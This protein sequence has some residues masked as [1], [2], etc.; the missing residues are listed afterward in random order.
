VARFVSS[1]RTVDLLG[2]QQIAGIPTAIHE[3]FKNAHDAYADNVNVDFFRSDRL[4]VVRD[5]GVGMTREDLEKRWLVVG[6]PSKMGRGAVLRPPIDSKKQ[7]RPVLG[8]KGIGRLAVGI[9]GPQVLVVSRAERD[10]KLQNLA[11][12]YVHWAIFAEPDLSLDEIEIPVREFLDPGALNAQAVGEMTDEFAACIMT[13]SKSGRL[14]PNRG[15]KILREV[16]SF[17]LDP[18]EQER[19]LKGPESLRLVAGNRGTQFWVLPAD[20]ILDDDLKEPE[21]KASPMALALLGFADAMS[22]GCPPPVLRVAFRDHRTPVDVVDVLD[23]ARFFD[24]GDFENADHLICGS[25]DEFGQFRGSI[26]VYGEELRASIPFSKAKGGRTS[27]G[28]FELNIAYVHGQQRASTLPDVEW[29]RFMQRARKHGGVYVYLDGIRVLPFGSPEFDWLEIEERRSRSAG[30][31]FFSH[32]VMCGSVRL[33]RA[34]NQGL[35]EKAGREG[36]IKNAAYLDLRRVLV[37]LLIRFAADYF[38]EGGERAQRFE[39]ERARLKRKAEARARRE[40]GSRAK[41][42]D[43]VKSLRTA[44]GLLASPSFKEQFEQIAAAFTAK[45]SAVALTDPG[46][47]LTSIEMA[48]RDAMN[49]LTEQQKRIQVQRPRVGIKE[50]IN[51]EWV[52]HEQMAEAFIG[53]IIRPLRQRV[54]DEL[55][56][57][58]SIFVSKE[59]ARERMFR[60][61]AEQSSLVRSEIKKVIAETKKIAISTTKEVQEALSDAELAA[62]DALDAWMATL[63]PRIAAA[64]DENEERT[65]ESAAFEELESTR[66]A[67]L[68]LAEMYQAELELITGDAEADPVAQ[69]EALEQ[70]NLDLRDRLEDEVE[71]TQLGMTVEII[72]HEFDHNIREVRTLINELGL[73]AAKNS[74]LADLQGR[75]RSAFQHLDGYLSLFTPLQRRLNRSETTIRGDEI[76]MYLNRIFARRLDESGAKIEATDRFRD[77][78]F[79]GYPSVYFSVFINLV[80]NAIFW[81]RER[82]IRLITL[83]ADNSGLLVA[84][85]GLGVPE[86]YRDAIF[87]RRF[88]LKPGGRGLGLA[89]ARDALKRVGGQLALMDTVTGATF[90]IQLPEKALVDREEEV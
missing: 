13:L 5:D 37:D 71:A 62:Y 83:D 11:A 31:Y 56:A 70:E 84:D 20:P 61:A 21:D 80:D 42:T 40:K 32:R 48:A 6:T 46:M 8:E 24:P 28:P 74:R 44:Q 60:D 47:A 17:R 25:V 87:D 66:K 7:L 67:A 73:W 23:A 34:S 22:P 63:P 77:V 64:K 79:V 26:R 76:V 53:E 88:T 78:T 16:A 50:H 4:L 43:F 35:E 41:A 1:A 54:E 39:S 59:T 36:F 69:L 51:G 10:G 75:L 45:S 86:T 9:V 52:L 82:E 72:S 81:T 57:A 2:R 58:R 15:E 3:L 65:I 89:I 27:C 55:R 38:R 85:T 19:F 30:H 68:T 18:H 14:D 29:I 12:A 49:S 90:R 33:S